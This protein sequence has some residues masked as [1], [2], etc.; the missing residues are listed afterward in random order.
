[1]EDA[2]SSGNKTNADMEGTD[3][4]Q[5]INI[6]CQNTDYVRSFLIIHLCTDTSEANSRQPFSPICRHRQAEHEHLKEIK[7]LLMEGHHRRYPYFNLL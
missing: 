1:M 5:R 3:P 7:T 4:T 2:K 6:V